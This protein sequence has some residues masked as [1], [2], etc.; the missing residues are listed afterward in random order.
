MAT[1]EF[2]S[3]G[4]VGNQNPQVSQSSQII[5]VLYPTEITDNMT[6]EQKKKRQINKNL[7]ALQTNMSENNSKYNNLTIG[8]RIKD[9]VTPLYNYKKHTDGKKGSK[10]GSAVDLGKCDDQLCVMDFYIKKDLSDEKITEIRNQIIENLPSNVGLVKTAHGGL[11]VYLDRDG[12]PL[13]NNSQIKIIKTDNFDV[14]I[15]AHIDENQRL[16]VL[17]KSTYRPQENNQRKTL[18]YED[19]NNMMEKKN[20]ATLNDVL[21]IYGIDLRAQF[22]EEKP[23]INN[24]GKLRKMSKEFADLLVDGI[25]HLQIHNDAQKVQREITLL[26]LFIGLNGL[27]FV[28]GLQE[29]EIKQYV[30]DAYN[31]VQ[32]QNNLT[33]NAIQNWEL[34]KSRFYS[35]ANPWVL[36]KIVKYHNPQYYIDIIKPY[37]AQQLQAAGDGNLYNYILNWIAFVIQNVGVKSEVTLILQGSQGIGKNRFTDV[38][39]EL[40]AGQS[41]KII[42]DIDEFTGKF[43]S[44]VENII[45]GIANELKNF[46]EARYSN[47]DALKSI[48]TD[49]QIRINEKNQPRRTA[50]NV[51]NLI[52]VTNNDFPVKIEV[53]DRR[54]VVCRCKA[55]HRDDVEYF[56]SLSNGFTTEFYNNLFTY[57]MTRNI[58]N[59]NQRIIPFTEAKKDIIRASRSQLDDVILQNYQAFKEGVPCTIALQFKPYDVKEKSFQLQLKN[60]CQRIRKTINEKRTWIYKLNEDLIKLYDRL[61]EED[62]DIND[63][64]NEDIIEQINV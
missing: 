54:Y 10:T 15:F 36:Q 60:K 31:K 1:K 13:K 63:D 61:R 41:I 4:C 45:L 30:E 3:V 59:W 16:V 47:M 21:D 24:D 40:L 55:V 6:D 26:C 12:Y 42:T 43:N 29:E 39:C 28:E 35:K 50:E 56:T 8:E 7:L 5:N 49:N 44:V 48:I 9:A 14:D 2:E 27:A 46:G 18:K 22:E 38:L 11:H 23:I 62:Q 57:F 25:C 34:K 19:L 53:N 52:M 33:E 64:I 51:M 32:A 17:P 37:L 58:S 20:L